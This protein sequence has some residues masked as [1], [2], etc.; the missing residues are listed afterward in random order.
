MLTLPSVKITFNKLSDSYVMHA[1]VPLAAI[2]FWPGY[3]NGYKADLGVLFSDQA[4]LGN[5]G[6]VF[7]SGKKSKNKSDL[8]ELIDF[9]PLSWG[10]FI[11]E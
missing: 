7:W 10:K 4:G 9:D 8:L 5:A 2:G 6:Y 3:G 1:Q 11:V